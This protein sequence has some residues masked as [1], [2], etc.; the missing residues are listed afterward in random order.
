MQL[1]LVQ[2]GWR[3]FATRTWNGIIG[4][5]VGRYATLAKVQATMV[6]IATDPRGDAKKSIT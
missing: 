6:G 2:I 4:E 1:E 3:T 5:A